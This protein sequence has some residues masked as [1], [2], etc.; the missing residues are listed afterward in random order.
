MHKKMDRKFIK[1]KI[2][3]I[4]SFKINWLGFFIMGYPGETKEDIFS[5]LDFM[6]DLNP[7]YAEINI[8]NPLPC[9]EIWDKLKMDGHIEKEPD[10][11]TY[12]QASTDKNFLSEKMSGDEFE[13]LAI[14]VAKEFDK[15]NLKQRYGFKRLWRKLSSAGKGFK[16]HRFQG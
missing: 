5:T 4:D 15:H 11:L 3:L 13:K 7:A 16:L 1:Q 14:Y 2:D 9:T 12:S 6:K 10:F 8:F